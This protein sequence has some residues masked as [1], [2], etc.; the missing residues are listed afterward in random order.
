MRLIIYI[1]L[2][3]PIAFMGLLLTMTLANVHHL[4]HGDN[5]DTVMT[6]MNTWKKNWGALVFVF[7]L[8]LLWAV[9]Y[10]SHA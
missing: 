4:K 8:C 6:E 1:I 3:F 5:F 7:Y 2:S 9:I 10:F